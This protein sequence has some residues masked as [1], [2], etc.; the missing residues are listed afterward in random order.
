MLRAEKVRS[1][2]PHGL[3]SHPAGRELG[4][5]IVCGKNALGR[6]G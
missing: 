5:M 1:V 6:G 2:C 3:K 4:S